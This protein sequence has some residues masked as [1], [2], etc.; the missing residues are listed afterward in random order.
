MAASGH[1]ARCFAYLRCPTPI[2]PATK[3]HS[4]RTTLTTTEAASFI[5]INP[6]SF[7]RWARNHGVEP[8]HRVRVGRS[9]VTAWSMADL[10]RVTAP[11]EAA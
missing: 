3:K 8:L 7:R 4:V 6:R 10:G 2:D 5:G 11:K 1:S 9:T